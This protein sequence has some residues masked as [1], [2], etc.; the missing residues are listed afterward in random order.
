MQKKKHINITT[1]QTTEVINVMFSRLKPDDRVRILSYIDDFM[2]KSL[3][4]P[5]EQIPWFN[6]KKNKVEDCR[7]VCNLMR[8]AYAKVFDHLE[9]NFKNQIH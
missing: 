5:K 7:H 1:N 6:P 8:I 3:N 2:I 4:I 9:K